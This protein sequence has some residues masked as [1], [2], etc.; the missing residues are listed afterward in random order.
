MKLNQDS[1][2]WEYCIELPHQ[3]IITE[4]NNSPPTLLELSRR[5]FYD[6]ISKTV[7][8]LTTEYFSIY[9]DNK[10]EDI[11]DLQNNF[12]NIDIANEFTN[13]LDINGNEYEKTV[14]DHKQR[15]NTR[16]NLYNVPA[17]II[18]EYYNF[19][20]SFI[21]TDLC[22][23]PISRCENVNCRNP[24]FDFAFYEFCLG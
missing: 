2:E 7:K 19:I 10:Y 18:T 21:K 9:S 3:N 20:P 14:N 23:G 1:K 4:T 11:C 12:K 15:M 5:K 22:N 13:D 16:R 8:N 6:T 17:D 24:V